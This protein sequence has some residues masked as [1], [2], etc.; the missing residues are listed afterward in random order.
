MAPRLSWKIIYFTSA[1][2]GCTVWKQ[3]FRRMMG[4]N[5][6]SK[7]GGEDLL[8][9]NPATNG[10]TYL[11]HFNISEATRIMTDPG[12]VQAIFVR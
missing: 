3:L 7:Q 6:W 9:W 12:W 2:V 8:P 10:L 4:Y 5:N 1:K 11:R